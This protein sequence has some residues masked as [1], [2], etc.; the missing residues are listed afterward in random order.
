MLLGAHMAPTTECALLLCPRC[1][2]VQT[3]IAVPQYAWLATRPCVQMVLGMRECLGCGVFAWVA[4][5]ALIFAYDE[6]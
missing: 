4:V 3:G 2:Q 6:E 1:G 5:P